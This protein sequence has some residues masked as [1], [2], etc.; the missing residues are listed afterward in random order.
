MAQGAGIVRRHG[1]QCDRDRGCRHDRERAQPGHGRRTRRG[2]RGREEGAVIVPPGGA[3]VL[4]ATRPVDFRKGMDGLAA[5]AKETLA[6]DPFSGTI[7]DVPCQACRPR[8]ASVLGHAPLSRFGSCI[9]RMASPHDGPSMSM[10]LARRQPNGSLF[11]SS[12]RQLREE[13]VSWIGHPAGR[14]WLLVSLDTVVAVSR[15]SPSR[16]DRGVPHPRCAHEAGRE[17]LLADRGDACGADV[18]QHGRSDASFRPFLSEY[19]TCFDGLAEADF[20]GKDC[21]LRE[22]GLEGK[23]RRLDPGVDSDRPAHREEFQQALRRPLRNDAG[24]GHER[25]A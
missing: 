1:R 16:V 24:Q 2:A 3:R 17:L 14:R 7:P 5:L 25:T 11:L 19:Q 18:F 20:V 10:S 23:K 13:T 22:G 12:T 6:Q 21:T 15:S 8:Q 4:V 9:Q